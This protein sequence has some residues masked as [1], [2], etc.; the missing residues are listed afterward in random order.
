MRGTIEK[1][2]GFDRS[3][4]SCFWLRR[5]PLPAGRLPI[6]IRSRFV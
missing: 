2:I 4:D 3:G 6:P 5:E 1:G